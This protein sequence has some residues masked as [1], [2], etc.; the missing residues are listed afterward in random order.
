MIDVQTIKRVVPAKLW[1]YLGAVRRWLRTLPP[2]PQR[3]KQRLLPDAS[4]S[5]DE[6][7]L[8]NKVNSRI[9]YNDGMYHGDGLH[10]FKVG[11]SAIKCINEALESAG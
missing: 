8:L 6:R 4:L 1:P 10:Y 11:L 9:Y 5:E 2:R 3:G 7:T